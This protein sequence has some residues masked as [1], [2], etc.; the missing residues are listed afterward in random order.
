MACLWLRQASDVHADLS[1]A[2][3]AAPALFGLALVKLGLWTEMQK[4][5]V[6]RELKRIEL[7]C[8][9]RSAGRASGNGPT[10]HPKRILHGFQHPQAPITLSEGLEEYYG[11]NPGLKRGETLRPVAREF[12]RCHD[13]AHVVFGCGTSLTD[14]AVVKLSS[15]FGTTAGLRVLRGYALF[16]SLDIYRTVPLGEVLA[17]IAVAPVIVPRTILKRLRQT[18]RW[19]WSDFTPWLDRPLDELRREFGI[20]I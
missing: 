6:V 18:K 19:P 8:R 1:L 10:A 20:V 15:V 11:Q 4:N 16:E 5:N 13:A 7:Q 12:F 14:E 9:A 17:A 2:G 3:G